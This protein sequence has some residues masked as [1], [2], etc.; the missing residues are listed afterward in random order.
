PNLNVFAQAIYGRSVTN[1][2]AFTSLMFGPWR[3]PLFDDNAFMPPSLR[4]QMAAEGLTSV[5]FARLASTADL[6]VARFEQ[7]NDTLSGTV[8]F[9]ADYA[10]GGLFD[11]WTL[12][13]YYQFGRN[14]NRIHEFNFPR[15]DRIFQAMDAVT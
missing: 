10:G 14:E 4:A 1:S 15:V 5:G 6:G 3:A 2:P 7:E 11:G 12:D 9:T 13:G 8:G